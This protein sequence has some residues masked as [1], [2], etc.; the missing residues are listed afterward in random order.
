[1]TRYLTSLANREMQIKIT[2]SYHSTTIIMVKLGHSYIAGG[3]VKWY[4]H[5][6]KLAVYL[7]VTLWEKNN[8]ASSYTT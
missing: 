6:G 7:K 3:N 4:S 8:D 2:I 5:S 1:M